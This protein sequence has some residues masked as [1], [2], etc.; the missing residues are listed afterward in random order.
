MGCLKPYRVGK[1]GTDDQTGTVNHITP[2]IRIAA[3]DS[4]R[5]E[6]QSRWPMK[7]SLKSGRQRKSL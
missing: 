3:R 1:V 5:Q 4:Q 7:F 6:Y 2:E